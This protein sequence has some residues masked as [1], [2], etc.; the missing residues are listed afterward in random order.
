METANLRAELFQPIIRMNKVFILQYTYD[1]DGRDE[2]K[3][4]GVYSTE[5]EAQ[6]AINRLKEQNIFS[7][8]PGCFFING[9]E[10]DKDQWTEEFAAMK[11]GNEKI[12]E[13]SNSNRKI[14]THI[15]NNIDIAE[16]VSSAV[17]I[18]TAEDGLDLLGSLYY[19]GFDRIILHEQNITPAFFDLKTGIAGE[20]L[21]KFS[22]YRVRLAIVGDFT[23]Y[24][25]KSLQDFIFESNKAGH[26]VFVN[27]TAEALDR[28]S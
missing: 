13:A 7:N 27:S 9:Y 2:T 10:V 26:I 19:Q 18:K 16:V 15:M 6:A 21:Q 3:F 22:T 28:L 25:S 24:S 8:Q 12:A 23:K 20:V 14:E 4:I 5:A 1:K 11:N 17:V